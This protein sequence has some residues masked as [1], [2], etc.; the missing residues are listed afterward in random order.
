MKETSKYYFSGK[1]QYGMHTLL[2]H[3]S[4]IMYVDEYESECIDGTKQER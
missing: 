3:I 1:L 2:F 4:A